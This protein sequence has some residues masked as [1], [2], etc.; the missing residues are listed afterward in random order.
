MN[1]S[2]SIEI[3]KKKQ[4]VEH[5]SVLCQPAYQPCLL[6][7]G[8]KMKQVPVVF[9]Y[10]VSYLMMRQISQ[11]HPWRVVEGTMGKD[12]QSGSQLNASDIEV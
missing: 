2:K 1:S 6:F 12:I 4:H 9:L 10:I 3:L 11:F 5:D 7:N 8:P